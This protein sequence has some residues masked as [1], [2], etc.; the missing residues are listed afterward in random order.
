[1]IVTSLQSA[2][3]FVALGP[4]VSLALQYLRTFKPGTPDG[5]YDVFGDN[6]FALVSTYET[7]PSAER[8]FEAHHQ[9]LDV[10]F[11]AEGEERILHAPVQSLDGETFYSSEN[12][13]AF[14]ADPKVSSS[15]LLRVGELAILGPEDAH[16]PGCMAGARTRVKK[17]VVKVRI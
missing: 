8:R 17:V 9:H 6:V 3:P 4:G 11:I 1:M 5:R 13:T 7:G 16:K 2:E 14:F 12:D 10:Q 15:I